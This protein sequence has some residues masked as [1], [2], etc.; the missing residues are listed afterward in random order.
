MYD[1]WT[2]VSFLLQECIVWQAVEGMCITVFTTFG[3]IF[4]RSFGLLDLRTTW[5]SDYEFYVLLVLKKP[6]VRLL[7]TT[8]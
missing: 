6:D 8:F 4:G 5:L 3:Q 1:G 7:Q 2:D